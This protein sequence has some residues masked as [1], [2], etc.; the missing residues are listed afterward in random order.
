MRLLTELLHEL[1]VTDL[2]IVADRH[3]GVSLIGTIVPYDL[4][5]YLHAV[6]HIGGNLGMVLI[7]ERIVAV[8]AASL[9]VEIDYTTA[10]ATDI[11]FFG[12]GFEAE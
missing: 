2:G 7:A 4:V 9:F 11:N 3:D 6:P 12:D 5:E 8:E 10:G 1:F